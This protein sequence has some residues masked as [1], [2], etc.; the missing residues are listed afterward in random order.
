MVSI[1]ICISTVFFSNFVFPIFTF[2][3]PNPKPGCTASESRIASCPLPSA[4]YTAPI[5]DLHPCLFGSRDSLAG[6]ASQAGFT[7]A[8]ACRAFS[9]SASSSSEA[10]VLDPTLRYYI[11]SGRD[12]AVST[13]EKQ[14]EGTGLPLYC[15]DCR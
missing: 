10:F 5:P 1:Q 12:S 6:V 11:H 8:S 13:G 14:R 2:F 9:L 7:V 15:R 4:T 3:I